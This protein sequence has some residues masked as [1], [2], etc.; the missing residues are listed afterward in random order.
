MSREEA[1]Q[2]VEQGMRIFE[3]VHADRPVGLAGLGDMGIGNTTPATALTTVLTGVPVAQVTGRGTGLDDA[4]LLRKVRVIEQALAL[5][6]PDPEDALDC[7]SA[8]GGLEIGCLAGITLAAAQHRVPVVLDG[9]I[10][11]SAALVACRIAP[12]AAGYLIASHRS[13]EPGHRVLLEDL[14]LVPLLDLQLRLGEG[15]G[16]ALGF[17]LVESALRLLAE[18]AT[19]DEAGVSEKTP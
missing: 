9:F 11:T 7:L 13:V 15:T 16:A 14:G 3:Q 18:M 6:R 12:E 1:E 2:I 17:S 5:H 10:T 19:F 4:Q 8:V